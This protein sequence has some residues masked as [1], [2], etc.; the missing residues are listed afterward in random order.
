MLAYRHLH[1]G[2]VVLWHHASEYHYFTPSCSGAEVQRLTQ[3]A[4][5]EVA[6]ATSNVCLSAIQLS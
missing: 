3:D 1:D 2:H 5:D 6:L 4:A